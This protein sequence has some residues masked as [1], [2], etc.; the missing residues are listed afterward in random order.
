MLM[1]LQ[2]WDGDTRDNGG[3]R[4]CTFAEEVFPR[5]SLL[6]LGAVER[7]FRQITSHARETPME[8]PAIIAYEIARKLFISVPIHDIVLLVSIGTL[9][10]LVLKAIA[11]FFCSWRQ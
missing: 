4:G 9:F 5:G 1:H 8:Y 7:I 11:M 6:H 10:P 2:P 3:R